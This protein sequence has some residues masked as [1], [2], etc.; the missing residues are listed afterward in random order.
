MLK[1]NIRPN[2]VERLIQM[3]DET[4]ELTKSFRS[5]RDKFKD[6]SLSSFNMA[7]LDRQPTNSKQYDQPINDEIGGL[8][9]GDIGE[10]NSNRDIII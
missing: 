8:I 7:I 4:N 6:D 1:K 2:I 3:L 5:I 9:V 10:F